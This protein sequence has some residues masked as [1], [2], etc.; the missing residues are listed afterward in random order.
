MTHSGEPFFAGTSEE[1]CRKFRIL[2]FLFRSFVYKRE[3][4][5]L[6]FGCIFKFSMF[7]I[8]KTVHIYR[9]GDCLVR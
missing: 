3:K 2:S 1:K 7:L 9:K 8:N 4:Y 5:L 6:I